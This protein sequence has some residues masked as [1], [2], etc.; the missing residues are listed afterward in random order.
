[1]CVAL[2]ERQTDS[3]LWRETPSL[4]LFAN[5]MIKLSL[6]SAK[7][8]AS[9]LRLDLDPLIHQQFYYLVLF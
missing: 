4:F 1:M 6:K 3:D 5:K 2:K 7:T 8:P 9:N